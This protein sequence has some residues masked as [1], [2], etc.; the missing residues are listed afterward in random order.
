MVLCTFE[1]LKFQQSSVN[2][3]LK[4]TGTHAEKTVLRQQLFRRP[5]NQKMTK[6]TCSGYAD[7]H[8][9]TM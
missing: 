5:P 2:E 9:F 1:L 4:A 3:Y 8:I 6:R 7:F